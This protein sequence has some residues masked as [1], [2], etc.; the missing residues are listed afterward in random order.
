MSQIVKKESE[1]RRPQAVVEG[2][3]R[4][5]NEPPTRPPIKTQ[6]A[7][8]EAIPP[9]PST[10]ENSRMPAIQDQDD[11]RPSDLEELAGPRAVS[12]L[13]VLRGLRLAAA[14]LTP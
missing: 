6:R 1:Q 5:S 7:Q 4:V 9:R 13:A 11:E 3:V 10:I 2:D 8:S 12:S 14:G